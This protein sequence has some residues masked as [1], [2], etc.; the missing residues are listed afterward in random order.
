MYKCKFVLILFLISFPFFSYSNEGATGII[1]ERMEKFQESKNLMRTIN[2][3]LS[4]N[5]FDIISQSAV[6]LNQWASEMHKYFPKGSEAS[7]SNKSQASGDIWSDPEGFKKAVKKFEIASAK[8]I[9]ISQN[10]NID[11]TVSSFRE[12]AGSCKGCH[13]KFRN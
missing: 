5:N 7:A 3:S 6:K 10:K 12:V 9:K 11:D 4:D 8:L 1:K 2:K 13:Q